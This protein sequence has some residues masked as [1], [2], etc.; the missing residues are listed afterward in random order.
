MKNVNEA[1]HAFIKACKRTNTHITL[2][3]CLSFWSGEYLSVDV[4][5]A[6]D[7]YLTA[8]EFKF[9]YDNLSKMW[10]GRYA[11]EFDN[12][13][14]GNVYSYCPQY[15]GWYPFRK[16]IELSARLIRLVN[17]YGFDTVRVAI[18]AANDAVVQASNINLPH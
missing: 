12:I 15:R 5:S 9:S 10:G 8:E 11:C 1:V 3:R 6:I 17:R 2:S 16:E 14:C 13:E 7:G 4:E 18:Q